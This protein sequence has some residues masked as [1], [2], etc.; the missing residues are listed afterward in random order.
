MLVVMARPP[1]GN[2]RAMRPRLVGVG[3]QRLCRRELEIALDRQIQLAANGFERSPAA[4]QSPFS[5]P[6]EGISSE[7]RL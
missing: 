3:G 4:W 7:V 2:D 1:L 5:R 6:I